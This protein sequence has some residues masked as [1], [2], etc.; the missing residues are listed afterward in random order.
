MMVD[1][2]EILL[3]FVERHAERHRRANRLYAFHKAASVFQNQLGDFVW[4]ARL[5]WAKA[6]IPYPV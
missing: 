4:H 6:N 3:D 1:P 2:V 5:V